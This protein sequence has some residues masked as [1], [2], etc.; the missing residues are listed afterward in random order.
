MKTVMLAALVAG[1]AL[2]ALIYDPAC[3]AT[4]VFGLTLGMLLG[5]A[6]IAGVDF[7]QWFR[8]PGTPS[9][10]GD[11]T[12][13]GLVRGAFHA[14]WGGGALALL[15]LVSTACTWSPDS[16]TPIDDSNLI[17]GLRHAAAWLNAHTTLL[18]GANVLLG[19]IG[20]I[21]VSQLVIEL[22]WRGALR[23]GLAAPRPVTRHLAPQEPPR[24]RAKSGR[25][26]RRLI[27]CCDGTWNWPESRRETN[28]VRLVR[29]L[30]PN[31][32]NTPQIVHYHQGV[33]TGNFID[34]AVGGGAGVG[35]TA[36]VKACYGFLV[37][38]YEA[39]DE[40]FIFGF[41]RGAFVARA[42]SGAIGTLGMMRK[43]EMPYFNDAW[44]WY[45]QDR[46]TRDP[47]VLEKL[48]PNRHR[49]VDVECLGVWD[50]V[51]ALGIP[52]S[53]LCAQTFAFHETELGRH[54]RHAFQALAIDE[55]RG[56]F[57]PAVW[58]PFDP[59]RAA[60]SRQFCAHAAEPQ[61]FSGPFQVLKQVWFPGVH[62]NIGGGYPEHG[63]SD[64][65][66]LWMLAQ[67]DA[68]RLLG[69]DR[70]CIIGALSPEPSQIYAG[71]T[72]YNS[73][74]FVWCLLGAPVPRP[75]CI[76]SA[77]EAIHESAWLR[78][79]ARAVPSRDC[80][81]RERRLDWLSA[82]ASLRLARLP[83]EQDLA[84]QPR[85]RRLDLDIP[86]KQDICGRIVGWISA[87]T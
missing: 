5:P 58:V 74:S 51:G 18:G 76:I 73:R 55:R 86:V 81:K 32:G 46:A 42:L 21:A 25:G 83:F 39:G 63:M 85:P 31:D 23:F 79:E 22:A 10:I 52:G 35:L 70:T 71:G 19:M 78:R 36:S 50:T 48:A 65:S 66:F 7:R 64:A 59:D 16:C 4:F 84:A 62:S 26:A 40:I 41:S 54:V 53:R 44:N 38:N 47:C 14:L 1:L 67:L 20:G 57:Q 13:I 9:E 11:D 37:D 87:R 12:F 30:L 60:Q 24:V 28:V 43:S 15:V 6:R 34:R 69:L 75:V 56:N 27:V 61:D 17:F 29:A 68:H 49:A 3:H 82:H 2:L 80:Y 72:M 8:D 33:G 77:T 45:W